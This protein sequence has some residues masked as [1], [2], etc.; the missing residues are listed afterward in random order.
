MNIW[1]KS[2]TC[3]LQV[4]FYVVAESHDIIAR[5]HFHIHYYARTFGLY[6]YIFV[7]CVESDKLLW[8]FV[9]SLDSSNILQ[10]DGSTCNGIYPYNLFGNL[11]FGCIGCS[12]LQ[13]LAAMDSSSRSTEST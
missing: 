6:L 11:L 8:V 5:H 7:A 10:T 1:W 12:H 13:W 3:L 4:L 2:A 9:L